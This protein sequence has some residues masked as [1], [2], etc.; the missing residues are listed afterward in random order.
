MRMRHEILNDFIS[1]DE[2]S[3]LYKL[4]PLTAWDRSRV[5]ERVHV[6][7]QRNRS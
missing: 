7:Q 2:F 1:I 3:F 5:K 4:N 6:P